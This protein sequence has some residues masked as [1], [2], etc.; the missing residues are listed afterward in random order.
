MLRFRLARRI[1]TLHR[2]RVRRAEELVAEMGAA[3]LSA[4]LGIE[5]TR[6][7][8]QVLSQLDYAPER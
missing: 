7:S 4:K 2:R 5:G 8:S 1:S 3:F 6:G